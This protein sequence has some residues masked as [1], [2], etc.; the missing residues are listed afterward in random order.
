M[1][2]IEDDLRPD[3]DRYLSAGLQEKISSINEFVDQQASTRF[4]GH[5]SAVSHPN[6]DPALM[7]SLVGY[8]TSEQAEPVAGEVRFKLPDRIVEEWP[9]KF[10]ITRG[11]G[12]T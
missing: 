5:P 12:S 9:W 3:R 2:R 6:I 10:C 11:F 1:H 7:S 8:G 4:L